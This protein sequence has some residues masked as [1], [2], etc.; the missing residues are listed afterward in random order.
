MIPYTELRKTQEHLKSL[1]HKEGAVALL[2]TK[3]LR[4]FAL[5]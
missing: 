4:E 1:N 2:L 5:S 3:T